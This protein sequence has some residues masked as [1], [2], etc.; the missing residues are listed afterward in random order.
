MDTNT[1]QA[2]TLKSFTAEVSSV[3]LRAIVEDETSEETQVEIRAASRYP[4]VPTETLT[5]A[6]IF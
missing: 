4:C 1:P 3:H 5:S 2:A 6:N